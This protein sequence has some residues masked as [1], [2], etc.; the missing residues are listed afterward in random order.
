MRQW[1]SV[2]N[3]LRRFINSTSLGPPLETT[4][5]RIFLR[6]WGFGF[7]LVQIDLVRLG[8]YQLMTQMC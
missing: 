3:R 8:R 1:N 2:T 5:F 7:Q 6:R 4:Y